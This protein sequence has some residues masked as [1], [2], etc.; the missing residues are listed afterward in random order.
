MATQA[1]IDAN[2]RNAL[3]STG[4]RTEQGKSTSRWNALKTGIEAASVVIPG[5]DPAELEQLTAEY[6]Q[7]FRPPSAVERFLVDSM[8]MAEWRLRRYR[9]IESQLWAESP[10]FADAFAGNTT[11]ARLQRRIDA[12]ERSYHRALRELRRLQTLAEP[13]SLEEDA[14]ELASFSTSPH[15][16]GD[17]VLSG[18]RSV[19]FP[20]TAFAGCR[21]EASIPS[22]RTEISPARSLA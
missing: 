4:P 6:H 19:D 17:V 16:V 10:S 11:I 14:S 15:P 13:E 5:E 3:K 1:Q 8:I 18:S 9:Q 21:P 12:A 22:P 2:R 20:H 7:Q